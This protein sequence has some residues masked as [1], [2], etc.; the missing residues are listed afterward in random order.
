MNFFRYLLFPFVYE[1]RTITDWMWTET[2]LTL[3]E[4]LGMEDIFCTVF[5]LKVCMP[6][7]KHFRRV[8]STKYIVLIFVI[9]LTHVQCWRNY[10]NKYSYKRGEKITSTVKFTVG[11]GVVTLFFLILLF[12]LAFFAFGYVAG[13]QNIPEDMELS[14]RIGSYKPIFTA[15]TA[16][17]QRSA[18]Q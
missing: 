15:Y 11:G 8:S 3:S 16:N 13:T 7:R 5:T 2:T 17:V 10:D 18:R 6:N 4:W 14:F 1:L 12:P 9:F